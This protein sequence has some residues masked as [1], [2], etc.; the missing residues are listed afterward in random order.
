MGVIEAKTI[1]EEE[2]LVVVEDN[3]I[4]GLLLLPPGTDLHAHPLVVN[5]QLVLQDKSSCFSALALVGSDSG[6]EGGD[7]IDAC[8]APGNK[9]SHLVGSGGS[10]S[11]GRSSGGGG[12]G[13]CLLFVSSSP[14]PSSSPTTITTTTPPLHPSRQH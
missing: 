2:G 12:G 3:H 6:Y 14:F 7:V 11:S 1:L 10:G 4:P 9:T 13:D 5:G 8:A